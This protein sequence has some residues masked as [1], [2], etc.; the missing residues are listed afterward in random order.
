MLFWYQNFQIGL[1]TGRHEKRPQRRN[2]HGTRVFAGWCKADSIVLD[3]VGIYLE[4][5]PASLLSRGGGR[6]RRWQLFQKRISTNIE[7]WP[8]RWK[9]KPRL[10]KAKPNK[11][12]G[13]DRIIQGDAEEVWEDDTSLRNDVFRLEARSPGSD[14]G[15]QFD[16]QA[17]WDHLKYWN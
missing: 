7:F 6:H 15:K 13:I 1:L 16:E 8:K 10:E 9:R 14:K 4:W 2:H 11:E 12:Q 5:A 3:F 17:G